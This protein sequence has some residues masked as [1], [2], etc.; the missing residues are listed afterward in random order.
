MMCSWHHSFL[1]LQMWRIFEPSVASHAVVDPSGVVPGVIGG[2]HDW[3][4]PKS[5]GG[6]GLDCFSYFLLVFLAYVE[7]PYRNLSC[8]RGLFVIL[9]GT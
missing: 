8:N 3:S 5:T 6:E 2:G 7:D 1:Y 4:S 9:T